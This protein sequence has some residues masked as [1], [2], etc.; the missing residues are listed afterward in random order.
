MLTKMLEENQTVTIEYL[1]AAGNCKSFTGI[2]IG[3]C[4]D[5]EVWVIKNGKKKKAM[6]VDWL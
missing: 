3:Y 5:G 6:I 1:T 2:L 4:T